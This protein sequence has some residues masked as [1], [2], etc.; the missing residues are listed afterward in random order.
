MWR[1]KKRRQFIGLVT[2]KQ[3]FTFYSKIYSFKVAIPYLH[4]VDRLAR[5]DKPRC[6]SFPQTKKN[7]HSFRPYFF[8]RIPYSN[9]LLVVV[10]AEHQSC[11]PDMTSSP[12]EIVYEQEFPCHKLKLNDLPRRRL[13][14]CF[15]EHPDVSVVLSK[16]FFSFLLFNWQISLFL[17]QEA[18]VTYCGLSPPTFTNTSVWLTLLFCILRQ[19]FCMWC[20]IFEHFSITEK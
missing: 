11:N 20:T 10:N 13:D 6:Q 19:M 1:L 8:K 12:V 7:F 16:W 4:T 18:N 14:E 17:Y 15:T 2:K 9:L 5:G 3:I